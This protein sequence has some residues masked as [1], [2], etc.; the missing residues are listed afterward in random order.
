LRANRAALRK[1]GIDYQQVVFAPHALSGL[2]AGFDELAALLA[3]TLG[4]GRGSILASRGKGSVEVLSDAGTVARR[5]VEIPDRC[6]N[7]GAMIMRNLAWQM[8]EQ[9]GD[10]AAMASVLARAIGRQAMVMIQ[11]GIDPVHIR[12]GLEYALP[13]ALARLDALAEP[14][15]SSRELSAVATSMTGDPE[16]GAVLGEIVDILGSAASVTF[17]ELPF[18]YLDR[19]YVD[20]AYWRAY[21]ASRSMLPEGQREVV[22]DKP[23]IMLVD[24]E[25]NEIDDILGGL[26]F[27]ARTDCTR[28]LLIV[29]PKISNQVLHAIALNQS[30]GTVSATVAVLTS[31]GLALTTDLTDMA[32]LTGG[33]VLADVRG[34]SPRFALADHFGAA[35]R[36]IISRDSLTIVGGTGDPRAIDERTA[37]VKAQLSRSSPTGTDREELKKRLARLNCGTAILKIGARSR[38]ELTNRRN[39]AEKAFRA[40][41]GMVEEGVVPGGGVALLECRPAVSSARAACSLP[42]QE[43]GVE[44][45]AAALAEPFLQL[46]RNH[47]SMH[48][49]LALARAERLGCD[50]G[51]DVVSGE[52]VNVRERGIVDSV[53]VAKGALQSAVS[54]AIALLTTGVVILPADSKREFRP[55]P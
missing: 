13:A 47:G 26:E 19:E 31:T 8:H 40:L 6:R 29:A 32:V 28:V 33:R 16:L 5:I 10:G 22:L 42:G 11:A 43:H 38:S 14:A 21:P 4:P 2:V 7:T 41:T 48:P 23:V 54:A 20:G 51:F 34:T 45:L 18:P 24:Q 39:E 9:Y 25:I 55:R 53:T 27:A 1:R 52:L 46:V 50:F 44:V 3:L 37:E 30:R 15:G 36:A 35:R 49:A 12:G 17:E